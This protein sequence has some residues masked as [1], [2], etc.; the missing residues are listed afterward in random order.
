MKLSYK[1]RH[2]FEN[3][4]PQRGSFITLAV[5]AEIK[6]KVLPVS[7]EE[8]KLAGAQEIQNPKTNSIATIWNP[9]KEK[10]FNV[11]FTEDEIKVLQKTVDK[12]DKEENIPSEYVD[13][14]KKIKEY[15]ISQEENKEK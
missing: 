5:V 4:Y 12:L 7:V 11:E 13:L 2:W 1:E 15:K 10:E 8:W 14:C 3:L 6:K 9:D